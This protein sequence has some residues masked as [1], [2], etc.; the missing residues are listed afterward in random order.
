MLQPLLSRFEK[1][2][3]HCT[4]VIQEVLIPGR[5]LYT[6]NYIPGEFLFVELFFTGSHRTVCGDFV[7]II[8]T[9]TTSEALDF[10][11]RGDRSATPEFVAEQRKRGEIRVELYLY[12]EREREGESEREGRERERE[13][14]TETEVDEW[15]ILR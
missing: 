4:S 6:V 1:N 14:G 9:E 11:R 7:C 13:K 5:Y 8:S 3:F 12:V 15:S 2:F 10:R